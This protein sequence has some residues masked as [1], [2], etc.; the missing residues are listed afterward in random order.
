MISFNNKI[1]SYMRSRGVLYM[2]NNI[3]CYI[4]VICIIVYCR[5]IMQWRYLLPSLGKL[6]NLK[7]WQKK[8]PQRTQFL[9]P[10]L[11]AMIVWHIIKATPLKAGSHYPFFS[12]HFYVTTGIG[13]VLY[14]I[15]LR[16]VPV[17]V[18][19]ICSY[20]YFQARG[21]APHFF[22]CLYFYFLS[23]S[24]RAFWTCSP[25]L[26]RIFTLRYVISVVVAESHTS[27]LCCPNIVR[28]WRWKSS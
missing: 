16:S 5:N 22:L 11:D 13:D 1:L 26:P 3:C 7:W 15:T 23:F 17:W 12:F 2:F 24:S 4:D 28:D 21:F 6:W 10:N 20:N 27:V 14:V 8:I 18:Y 19:K 9:L 25:T